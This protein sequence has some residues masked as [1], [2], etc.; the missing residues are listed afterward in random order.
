MVTWN[1]DDPREKRRSAAWSLATAFYADTKQD[2]VTI[3]KKLMRDWDLV[4][5]QGHQVL[6]ESQDSSEIT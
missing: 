3:Y 2:P 5:E 6:D 1:P 4:D